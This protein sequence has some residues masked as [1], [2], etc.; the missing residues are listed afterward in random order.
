M[1]RLIGRAVGTFGMK[2]PGAGLDLNGDGLRMW[3][4]A[5]VATSRARHVF[6]SVQDS[7]AS[8]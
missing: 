2:S 4:E 6:V 3:R 7:A 8:P 5:D 1:V